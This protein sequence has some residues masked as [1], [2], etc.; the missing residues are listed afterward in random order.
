[1]REGEPVDEVEAYRRLAEEVWGAGGFW[2]P[3]MVPVLKENLRYLAGVGPEPRRRVGM[4]RYRYGLV[5]GR[6]HTRRAVGERESCTADNV[7]QMEYSVMRWMRHPT[8]M[9]R[10]RAV[11]VWAREGRA[12]PPPHTGPISREAPVPVERRL[13]RSEP[14]ES[15][16]LPSPPE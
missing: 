10:I 9:R 11:L 3:E 13:R 4:V 5:D 14:R 2:E 12:G 1:M 7:R 16:P 8:C 6:M 15:L